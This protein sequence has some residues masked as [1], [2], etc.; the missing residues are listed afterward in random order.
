MKTQ[1]SV[2]VIGGPDDVL[3]TGHPALFAVHGKHFSSVGHCVAYQKAQLF[4][5]MATAH[6]IWSAS[7]PLEISSLS[8]TIKG[9]D[10]ANWTRHRLG[11][12]RMASLA[13]FDQNP[14]MATVLLDTGTTLLAVA[15]STHGQ[16]GLT[17]GAAGPEIFDKAKWVGLNIDGEALMQVRDMMRARTAPIIVDWDTS[18]EPA[19]IAHK[20][21]MCSSWFAGYCRIVPQEHWL[22]SLQALSVERLKAELQSY[23]KNTRFGAADYDPDYNVFCAW[24]EESFGFALEGSLAFKA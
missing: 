22:P 16:R 2:T 1:N 3:S 18:Q 11:I 12:T 24:V 9:F 8:R 4:R 13:K 7:D 17:L 6:R 19:S 10:E 20:I 15:D 21:D 5:D 23:V 14:D